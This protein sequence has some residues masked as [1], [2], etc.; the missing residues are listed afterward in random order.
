[1]AKS[2]HILFFKLLWHSQRLSRDSVVSPSV[3][4]ALNKVSL[5]ARGAQPM[6]S[7]GEGR[8]LVVLTSRPS[9]TACPWPSAH[10][11]PIDSQS[12]YGGS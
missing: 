11:A 2:V 6:T 12:H 5:R 10:L 9:P 1:M 8:G 4:L 3:C 7:G